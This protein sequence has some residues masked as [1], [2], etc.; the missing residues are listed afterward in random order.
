MLDR[1]GLLP[2]WDHAAVRPLSVKSNLSG[3]LL[4]HSVCVPTPEHPDELV[5]FGASIDRAGFKV[6]RYATP[7]GR[8][9]NFDAKVVSRAASS[10]FRMSRPA[11]NHPLPVA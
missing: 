2:R 5:A 10:G 3:G 4:F 7:S 9:D 11:Y 6:T 8:S 1:F